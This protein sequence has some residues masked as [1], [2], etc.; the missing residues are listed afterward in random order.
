MSEAKQA[1]VQE[2]CS[3][4][5]SD[6]APCQRPI[7]PAPDGVDPMPVCQ[8]HSKDPQKDS[9]QFHDQFQQEIQAILDGTSAYNRRKNTHDFTGFVFLAADFSHA[10][11]TQNANFSHAT[12]TQNANFSLATFTQY[13]DFSLATFTQYADFSHATFTQY[14]NFSFV[15]FGFRE[16][17]ADAQAAASKEGLAIADFQGTRFMKPAD[18]RFFQVNKKS[19]DGLR[20]RFRNCEVEEVDFTDV[21]WHQRGRRMVL[22][23]EIDV[24][25]GKSRQ[26]ELVAK[27]YR[28]LVSNFEKARAYDLA[29]DC[30]IG[31]MEMKR[32]DPR[33]S[34]LGRL[35][36]WLSV[37]NLYRLLSNYGSSYTRAVSV[38]LVFLLLFALL[39]P[40]FGLR[41]SG[42][43]LPKDAYYTA[44]PASAQT[45]T[46][47]WG[48]ALAHPQRGRELWRTFKAG[49]W[50][51]LE[52]A[53]FQKDPTVK[54]ADTWGRRLA[55]IE[56]IVIPGQLALFLLVLRRR[57]RR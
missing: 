35:G 57:F 54:P 16:E 39:F 36:R 31:A 11:F 50:A 49:I 41:M 2:T 33:N 26:Y 38:L 21:H 43:S 45:P 42:D 15:V 14:A 25:E 44:A 9:A 34:I 51:S 12:F 40:A 30:F 1:A 22:E 29:E 4:L 23:D 18:V 7:H 27:V 48:L 28:Q 6:G 52:V 32:L 19:Q 56:D 47:S 55:V 3:W 5:M 37:V 46:I 13:A 24:R 8:M 17:A 53:T 10:T 20:V